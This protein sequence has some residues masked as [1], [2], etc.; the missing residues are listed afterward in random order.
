MIIVCAHELSLYHLTSIL[1][2]FDECQR[3]ITCARCFFISSGFFFS[4]FGS[5]FMIYY[6]SSFDSN[7]C[8]LIK[9]FSIQILVLDMKY[10]VLEGE[11]HLMCIY[12]MIISYQYYAQKKKLFD[13]HCFVDVKYI[14]EYMRLKIK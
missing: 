7:L 8:L 9:W 11:Y 14:L 1:I 5:F 4:F 3:S 12:G 10:P 13:F 2:S 6:I